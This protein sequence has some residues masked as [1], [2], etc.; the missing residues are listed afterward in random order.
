LT[1]EDAINVWLRYWDGEFQHNI[2]ASYAVN[3]GRIS[4]VLKERT[5]YGSKAEAS[6]RLSSAA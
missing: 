2:A 3:P 5:H 6:K 1:F 4:E